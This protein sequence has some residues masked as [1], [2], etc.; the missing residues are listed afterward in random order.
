MEEWV[1]VGGQHD[2][3]W[4]EV[5]GKHAD[6]LLWDAGSVDDGIVD[7]LLLPHNTHHVGQYLLT[8]G[9]VDK[10]LL[11]VGAVADDVGPSTS[12]L[13]FVRFRISEECVI[14]ETLAVAHHPYLSAQSAIDD[15]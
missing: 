2:L 12:Q 3:V 8:C 10:I 5:E 11:R 13:G 9:V 15:G 4:L 6:M 1:A 7:I 14:D